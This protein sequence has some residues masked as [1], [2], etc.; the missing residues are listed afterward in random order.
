MPKFRIEYHN[1]EKV[2]T[3]V[4]AVIVADDAAQAQEILFDR[5]TDDCLVDTKEFEREPIEIRNL[6]VSEE[7]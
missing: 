2:T 1:V 7:D 6:E 3:A 4:T 5:E